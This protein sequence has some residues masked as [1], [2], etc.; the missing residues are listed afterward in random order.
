MVYTSALAIGLCYALLACGLFVSLRFFKIPD[1]TTDGSFT[2][3][4]AITAILLTQGWAWWSILPLALL[5]GMLCG[6]ATALISNRLGVDSL[7][8]G[9]LVMTALYSINLSAMGRS[10]LPLLEVR[11]FWPGEATDPLLIG[12]V[13]LLVLA[14]G[15][16]L[17]FLLLSD[18]GVALR[19]SGSSPTMAQAM[20]VNN[21]RM[22]MLGLAITN[23]LT[24]LS[25][26]LVSQ[27]QG[28]ADINMGVGVVITGLAAVLL[29]ESVIRFARI[30]SLPL[31]LLVVILGSFG[32]QLVL[33]LALSLGLH[34]NWLKGITAATVLLVVTFANIKLGNH[35]TAT[36]K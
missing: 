28:F 34:P 14:I 31:Q 1:I 35:G 6:A 8:S 22:K 30:R 3:G 10:N 29:A 23:G 7:L 36:V 5:A 13:A 16:S 12:R 26:F 20:G 15:A 21:G 17:C 19:A 27:Q 32:F 11:S 4:A 25:G 24:A 9:I 33:T 18:F 2:A